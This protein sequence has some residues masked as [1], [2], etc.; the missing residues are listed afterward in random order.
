MAQKQ[1]SYHEAMAKLQTALHASVTGPHESHIKGG[2]GVLK[3]Y[4]LRDEQVEDK[5]Q[6][7]LGESKNFYRDDFRYR[8][9]EI[10]I[11]KDDT[12]MML[13]RQIVEH[14]FNNC[15]KGSPP[16]W[17]CW[18]K[19]EK[20]PADIVIYKVKSQGKMFILEELEEDKL[21]TK[22]S[23]LGIHCDSVLV[24]YDCYDCNNILKATNGNT[25]YDE[26]VAGVGHD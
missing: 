22:L 1:K 6:F 14:F 4:Y 19:L 18:E 25:I 23:D 20:N 2:G 9:E 15:D 17:K 5:E 8:S 11:N 16:D 10:K 21:D 7:K 26:Y 24:T 12:Y 13:K 3:L